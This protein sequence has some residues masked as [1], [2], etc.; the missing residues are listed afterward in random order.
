MKYYI[1]AGEAS[2]DLHGSKLLSALLE[3]N[4]DAN[5]RFWGGDKMEMASGKKA[6]KHIRD[7]SFMGIT[8]VI[9]NLPEILGNFSLCK[10]DIT[11]FQPDAII[12]ID[13]SGFNLRIAKWAKKKGY[14]NFYF[15]SPQIWA[16]RTYRVHKII[17]S[18]EQVYSILPFEQDFYKQFGYDIT[19]VGHP[20][21]ERIASKTKE[22]HSTKRIAL[23]PGSRKQEIRRMLPV[24]LSMVD[25]FP[26]YDFVIAAAPSI[27]LSF[28]ESF[29]DENDRLC[30]QENA[31]YETLRNT[32]IALVTSGTATLEAGLI[33]T[34]QIVCYKGNSFSFHIAKKLVKVKYISLVNL[35]LDDAIVTE[36]IQEDFNEE[37]LEGCLAALIQD[38]QS[39]KNG[40]TRLRKDLDR[41]GAS[42][43]VAQDIKKRLS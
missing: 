33:G 13:Y 17:E 15:I 6:V 2:G 36:L 24:M 42:R 16:W 8:E 7:L 43:L 37:K 30:I 4:P 40:Y 10:N 39:I 23:L 21:L 29:I 20:L 31:T 28:Y 32:D 26:E 11:A 22:Q 14:R 5:I 27:P 25:K 41:G 19:Y 38:D 1:I 18:T 12:L 3:E 35:I 34:S 9:A